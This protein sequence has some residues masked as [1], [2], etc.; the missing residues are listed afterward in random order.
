MM[1]FN[2]KNFKKFNFNSVLK[3]ATIDLLKQKKLVFEIIQLFVLMIVFC[4]LGLLTIISPIFSFYL[5]LKPEFSI[6]AFVLL[7]FT[8]LFLCLTF[9]VGTYFSYRLISFALISIGKKVQDFNLKLAIKLFLSGIVSF[10]VSLFSLYELKL[11]LFGVIGFVLMLAGWAL[12]VFS[13][14][15]SL[16]II[17]SI[18]SFIIAFIL[19]FIYYIIVIRNFVRVSFVSI[20]LVEKNLGVRQS[21]KNSW[22]LTAGKAVLIFIIQLILGGIIWVVQQL[23][24]LPFNFATFPLL[25]SDLGEFNIALFILLFGFLFL[26]MMVISELFLIFGQV[27]VYSQISSKRQ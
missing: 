25:A 3:F 15:N 11:L 26:F 2:F 21:V 5:F 17:F 13:N 10:F 20:F 4:L 18:I 16:F 1:S 12:L 9:L 24:I 19:F 27:A 14:S 6:F 7:G 8:L 22:N 23:I